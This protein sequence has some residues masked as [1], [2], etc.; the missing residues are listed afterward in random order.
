MNTREENIEKIKSETFLDL[1]MK[2]CDM[3]EMISE[4]SRFSFHILLVHVVSY[5][6]YGKNPIG[7][8]TEFLGKHLIITILITISAIILYYIFFKRFMDSKI[9]KLKTTCDNNTSNTITESY[10]RVEYGKL[11]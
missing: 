1:A 9:K 4:A 2:K 7:P 11:S 3:V 5:S 8:N 6:I 10:N